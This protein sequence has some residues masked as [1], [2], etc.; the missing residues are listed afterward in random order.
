MENLANTA[1]PM[2]A[3]PEASPE[4]PGHTGEELKY[5]AQSIFGGS[6]HEAGK[7]EVIPEDRSDHSK[8]V[9][10]DACHQEKPQDPGASN[11]CQSETGAEMS[12][13]GSVPHYTAA[14]YVYN[15]PE[16]LYSPPADGGAPHSAH[17]SCGQTEAVS[18]QGF[19]TDSAGTAGAET[20]QGAGQSQGIYGSAQAPGQ[21]TGPSFDYGGPQG[22]PQRMPGFHGTPAAP[23]GQPPSSHSGQQFAGPSA[24]PFSPHQPGMHA[25]QPF[26]SPHSYNPDPGSVH[27]HPKSDQHKYG[28]F[29]GIIN[30]LA[31][32]N[33][34]VP[35]MMNFLESLDT[36]FWK[37]TLV[38]VTA[39]L[40]LTNET[41]K[42][43]IAG[44]L[45]GVWG[46]F[47]KDTQKD[48]KEK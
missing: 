12:Q 42:N 30:D 44:A 16:E 1:G 43:A 6:A 31:N 5:G 2:H 7:K 10:D 11:R 8:R 32:G 47:Q 20:G 36:Q 38:G 34:D 35:K 19:R 37:G 3:G 24:P 13:H 33:P 46:I 9:Q 26:Q 48:S 27:A 40:L 23:Y 41:V 15:R 14:G 17:C 28:Q 22:M 4:N 25:S 21:N 18:R 45:S 39:T 29:M